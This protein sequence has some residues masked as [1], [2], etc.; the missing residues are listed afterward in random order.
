MIFHAMVL[1][2]VPRNLRACPSTVGGGGERQAVR[3][4][5]E[6]SFQ[7]RVSIL[8]PSTGFFMRGDHGK[9]AVNALYKVLV[10][11]FGQFPWSL[12]PYNRTKW[13]P[14]YDSFS[15]V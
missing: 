3:T 13:K 5:I 8:Y 7:M 1:E 14:S 12:D 11:T 15:F 10:A 6:G 4:P 9:I 2:Q